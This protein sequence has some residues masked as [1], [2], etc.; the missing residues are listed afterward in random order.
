[1]NKLYSWIAMD[2]SEQ[3]LD[4]GH[5]WYRGE[6]PQAGVEGIAR[7][8]MRPQDQVKAVRWKIEPIRWPDSPYHQV[9]ERT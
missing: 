6:S 9:G 5:A 4:C 1:M 2:S 7:L 3:I 8:C